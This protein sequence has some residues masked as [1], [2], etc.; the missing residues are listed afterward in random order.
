MIG[1][2]WPKSGVDVTINV[3]E[4][5]D[6]GA[7]GG[8]DGT[9]SC[10][11]L[12]AESW[13]IMSML[14]GCITAASAAITD[15]GIDSVDLVTGGTAAIVRK[16]SKDTGAGSSSTY[17]AHDLYP[18]EHV[19]VLAACVVGYLQSRDETTHL[20]AKTGKTTTKFELDDLINPAIEG[21]KGSRAVLM[22]ALE[23]RSS[24]KP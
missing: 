1:D 5:E 17:I 11:P 24:P 2:K 4:M 14:S 9:D 8:L 15:A 22:A 6:G 20:W 21:A 18:S 10:S 23:E 13:S 19:E 7:W 3:L 16:R 12:I